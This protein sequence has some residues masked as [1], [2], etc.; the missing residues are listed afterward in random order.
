M[1]NIAVWM[2]AIT[3]VLWVSVIGFG[4]TLVNT[5]GLLFTTNDMVANVWVKS[6][7]A[8]STKQTEL[9]VTEGV[10][11]FKSDRMLD[12]VFFKH[13]YGYHNFMQ[14]L[15]TFV[16]CLLLLITVRKIDLQNPFTLQVAR[17]INIIGL[18]FI[19]YGLLSL[20]ASLYMEY[21]IVQVNPAVSS[22]YH[23]FRD[24]LSNIKIGVFILIL[25]LIYRVGVNFQQE[26]R[27]TI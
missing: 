10:L 19:V 5:T 11:S 1:K 14:S 23:D 12:R 7:V 21:R 9:R 18:A 22:A 3:V 6:S 15:F 27:L 26:N 20:G 16:V 17:H 24:D 2:K 25:G 13:V 8:P 4:I